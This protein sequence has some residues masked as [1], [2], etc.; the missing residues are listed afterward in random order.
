MV[1]KFLVKDVLHHLIQ[2]GQHAEGAILSLSRKL[3]DKYRK[4]VIEMEDAPD[5]CTITLGMF[6]GLTRG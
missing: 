6:R 1:Q 4:E 3:L 2:Q 5:A